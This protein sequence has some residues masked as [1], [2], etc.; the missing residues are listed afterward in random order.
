MNGAWKGV[1]REYR[2]SQSKV[3]KLMGFDGEI[4]RFTT[5]FSLLARQRGDDDIGSPQAIR[6]IS[7]K[8]IQETL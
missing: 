8:T 5:P 7:M 4:A 6:D 3:L 1:E 2:I